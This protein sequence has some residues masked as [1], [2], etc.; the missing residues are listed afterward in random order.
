MKL[1]M[2][3]ALAATAVASAAGAA[4]NHAPP[5]CFLTQ[6]LRSHTID[7]KDTI[8]LN[9]NGTDTYQVKTDQVCLAHATTHESM[10]VKD[11]GLGT[12]CHSN[13]LEIVVRGAHC[14]IA[15]LTKM[16]AAEASALP[17]ALQP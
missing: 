9:V 6:D 17:K 10:A 16:S 3:A 5:G 15:S 2:I 11:R 12:I 13:D 8:Y 4:S 7:G 1:L 14:H